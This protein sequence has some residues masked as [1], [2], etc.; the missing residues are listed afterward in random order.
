MHPPAQHE[1]LARLP[2]HRSAVLGACAAARAALAR[3]ASS[4]PEAAHALDLAEA[5]AREERPRQGE[6]TDVFM[7]LLRAAID[8]ADRAATGAPPN[9]AAAC[10]L[11]ADAADSVND[12][13]LAASVIAKGKAATLPLPGTPPP[14]QH[15]RRRKTGA[16]CSRRCSSPTRAH[17]GYD[18][19]PHSRQR[20]RGDERTLRGGFPPR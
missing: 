10:E 9:V 11:A 12:P 4:P 7:A 17:G 8:A 19:D 5:W 2:V 20:D 16:P 18:G 13:R 3:L 6:D 14:H 1:A 15:G